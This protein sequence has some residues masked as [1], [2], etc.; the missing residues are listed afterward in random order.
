MKEMM[1]NAVVT[2]GGACVMGV[3]GWGFLWMLNGLMLVLG[4]A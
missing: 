2:V 1:K 4:I 3:A